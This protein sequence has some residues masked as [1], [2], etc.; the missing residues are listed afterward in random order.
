MST[1]GNQGLSVFRPDGAVLRDF[2][3]CDAHVQLIMG[4]WGSG[5]TAGCCVGKIWKY[6]TQQAPDI[7]G[8]RR[9]RWFIVRNTYTDLK[10]TTLNTWKEWFPERWPENHPAAG[11]IAFGEITMSRPFRQMISV[12]DVECEVLFLALDDEEDRKK[13]LSLE[14]TG[15]YFNEFREI[16]RGIIDDAT[17]RTGRFPSQKDKPDNVPKEEWPS[18][19]GVIGDTNA[20][21]E[22]HWFPIM[23]GDVPMP[24][25]FTEEDIEAHKKPDTWEFF[26]QPAGMLRVYDDNGKMTGYKSNPLAENRKYLPHNYYENM[27][28][29][30]KPSWVSINILNEYGKLVEGKPVFETFREDVHVS[31]EPLPVSEGEVVYVGIDFGRTPA[32]VFGQCVGGQWRILHELLAYNMGADRFAPLLRKELSARFPGCTFALYGDPAGDEQGQSSDDTPYRIF[33]A[34]GLRVL[35]AYQNNKLGLRLGA[36]ESCLGRSNT[37]NTGP[38]FLIDPSCK[39]VIA[40]MNGGYQCKRIRASGV[41]RYSEVPDKNQYSHP[42]DALQYMLLGAGEGKALLMTA[43]G[44]SKPI[45]KPRTSNANS[46]R[47][48][49][50]RR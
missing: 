24:D 37:W 7:Y 1:E 41:A 43:G 33:R 32:A 11:Q 14:C 28:K 46:R 45:H 9:T 5:K 12:G 13:L 42:A 50:S 39:T 36:V 18:W 4:P 44:S 47:R 17:G 30:K 6:A 23:A 27:I 16:E 22:E 21:H 29:G 49:R 25:H 8:R 10:N 19:H 31:K 40:A 35:P 2:I 20:P 3:R 38:G 26:F 15:F 48:R 34:N